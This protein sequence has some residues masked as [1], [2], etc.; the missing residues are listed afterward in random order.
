[1]RLILFIYINY[2][3]LYSNNCNNLMMII[4]KQYIIFGLKVKKF[5]KK[6]K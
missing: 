2:L 3:S 1:M 6:M 5:K 4:V